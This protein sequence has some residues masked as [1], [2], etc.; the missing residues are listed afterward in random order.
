MSN[1][2]THHLS[3]T[4]FQL[5]MD[6]DA[7]DSWGIFSLLKD[8]RLFRKGR[9]KRIR[10]ILQSRSALLDMDVHIFDYH[11]IRGGGNSVRRFEQ[12]VF[13]VQSKQL[14]LPEFWMKPES[15][16][17]KVGALLGIEDIDF[18]NYPEFSNRYL[19]KG[20]DE[21][22][23]RSTMNHQVLKFFSV[24]KNWCLEGVNYYL[25][26]YRPNKLLAPQQIVSFYKKGMHIVDMLSI[27]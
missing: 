6:F 10:N 19:L 16:L 26:F 21:D 3:R 27:P 7:Q 23:I 12:T 18:E 22:F 20:P 14:G 1:N 8:F 9:R 5:E 25:I 11:Y 17:D 24:E 2:R 4:A 15:I 13:F